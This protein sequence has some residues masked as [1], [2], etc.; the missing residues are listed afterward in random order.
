MTVGDATYVSCA[1]AVVLAAGP[2]PGVE[3]AVKKGEMRE[4]RHHSHLPSSPIDQQNE[5][6]L[7][8]EPWVGSETNLEV[9]L[10]I[11]C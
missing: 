3:T 1:T 9:V 10:E 11:C 7:N 8:S 6:C 5:K 2:T 4:R